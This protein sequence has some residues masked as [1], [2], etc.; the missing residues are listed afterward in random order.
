M[1]YD[2]SMPKNARAKI[3]NASDK[4][5]TQTVTVQSDLAEIEIL[6]GNLPAQRNRQVVGLRA[7]HGIGALQ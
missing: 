5:H 4:H 7:H 6:V 2:I 1:L 3:V